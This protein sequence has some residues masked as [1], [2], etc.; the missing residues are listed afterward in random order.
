MIVTGC[1]DGARVWDRKANLLRELPGTGGT[2]LSGID[3]SRDSDLVA[4]RQALGAVRVFDTETWTEVATFRLPAGNTV[5]FSPADN[6]LLVAG[7]EDGVIRGW[8]VSSELLPDPILDHPDEVLNLKFSPPNGRVLAVGM[9]GEAIR[10]WDLQTREEGFTTPANPAG[11]PW[12]GRYHSYHFDFVAFSPDGRLAAII[13]PK[14]IVS[15][16][17]IE[18]K[19]RLQELTYSDE[20]PKELHKAYWSVEF[21]RDSKRLYTGVSV[22]ESG[23]VE[24]WEWTKGVGSMLRRHSQK[25]TQWIWHRSMAVSPSGELL[26]TT[27]GLGKTGA[28]G[29]GAMCSLWKLPEMRSLKKL[30]LTAPESGMLN[31]LFSPDGKRLAISIVPAAVTLW[32]TS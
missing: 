1:A 32:D 29:E 24:V 22:E 18:Q 10:F 9:K 7:G 14:D 11:D 20:L 15:V 21:S 3:F 5:A 8:R 16:W 19:V 6:N 27:S 23:L 31:L 13:G 28:G 12:L 26:A 4:V 25:E 17:D 2:P 30:K